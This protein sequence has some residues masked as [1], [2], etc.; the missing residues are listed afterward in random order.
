MKKNPSKPGPSNI[1]IYKSVLY[2]H[3]EKFHF[4]CTLD[5]YFFFLYLCLFFKDPCLQKWTLASK[6][7][8]WKNSENIQVQILQKELINN[9]LSKNTDSRMYEAIEKIR[10]SC[11]A[12]DVWVPKLLPE[13]DEEPE[14]VEEPAALKIHHLL[15][16]LAPEGSQLFH[17][18]HCL[19]A[20]GA[21]ERV[22]HEAL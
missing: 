1:Y 8:S 19:Q 20:E 21:W 12:F 10:Q 18:T 5:L 14:I 16:T 2:W 11:R 9:N 13:I 6:H 3:D 7:F 4:L 17:T 22:F 15:A